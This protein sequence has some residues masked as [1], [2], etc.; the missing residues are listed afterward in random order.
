MSARFRSVVAPALQYHGEGT[1][2]EQSSIRL[3]KALNKAGR[4]RFQIC[5]SIRCILP[6][7]LLGVISYWNK[8]PTPFDDGGHQTVVGSAPLVS[9]TTI[10]AVLGEVSP[11]SLDSS[12]SMDNQ[13]VS[14]SP[15]STES[16]KLTTGKI[17]R[18]PKNTTGWLPE[19]FTAG[20]EDNLLLIPESSKMTA[21]KM[22]RD[23]LREGGNLGGHVVAMEVGMFRAKQCLTAA[24]AGFEVHCVEPSPDNFANIQYTVSKKDREIQNRVHL[25]NA[26]AGDVSGT[27][28]FFHAGGGTGDS[29]RPFAD[30][31]NTGNDRAIKSES[32]LVKVPSLRLDDI[33]ANTT[34][35]V[36]ALKVDTQGFEPNVF[37]G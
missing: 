37:A 33:V 9:E 35:G 18:T 16:Q 3:P 28:V 2:K 24:R 22:W 21:E 32:N 15:M 10:P 29:V 5:M 23:L 8:A 27:N 19:S 36:F 26:A 20:L 7:L 17:G 6:F 14:D 34:D 31:K 11:I 13:K 4:S 12:K 30:E 25:Y 1:S